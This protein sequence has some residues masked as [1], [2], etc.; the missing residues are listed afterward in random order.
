MGSTEFSSLT[1]MGISVHPRITASAPPD[2]RIHFIDRSL[3]KE[4]LQA[5][6]AEDKSELEQLQGEARQL[7]EDRVK[8]NDVRRAVTL[9]A[10]TGEVLWKQAVDVTDCTG[11]GIGR[12]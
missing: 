4:Q 3:T 5:L 11:V 12:S 1:T 10:K 2:G 7:A 8:R 6:L 9:D